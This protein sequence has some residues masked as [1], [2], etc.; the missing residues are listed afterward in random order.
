MLLL[1]IILLPMESY[2]YVSFFFRKSIDTLKDDVVK[3]FISPA[4]NHS[5]YGGLN[6][7]YKGGDFWSVTSGLQFSDPNAKIGKDFEIL[8][9]LNLPFPS[10][11]AFETSYLKIQPHYTKEHYF[12]LGANYKGDQINLSLN[13]IHYLARI[14]K[15]PNNYLNESTPWDRA[16]GVNISYHPKSKFIF[17]TDFKYDFM[18][19]DSILLLSADYAFK[20]FAVLS[21]GANLISSS[22]DDTYWSTFRTNDEVITKLTITY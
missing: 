14:G 5:F 18:T 12:Y 20:K 17:S 8:D 4:I 21:I 13:Y 15:I 1:S 16:L 3:V 10:S 6:Y 7:V 11:K 2:T 9:P 19:R 22:R